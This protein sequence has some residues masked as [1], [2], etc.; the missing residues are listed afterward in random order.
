M[1]IPMSGVR[2]G[3]FA[4]MLL[5]ASCGGGGGEKGSDPRIQLLNQSAG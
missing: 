4:A 2:L 1:K 5:L 3:L